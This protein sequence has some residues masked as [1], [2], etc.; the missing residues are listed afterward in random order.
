M[1]NALAKKVGKSKVNVTNVMSSTCRGFL[2]H[3]LINTAS[4]SI[5]M[6]I[7]IGHSLDS[8]ASEFCNI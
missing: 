7:K 8:F 1:E 3:S 6:V 5:L 2:E 4:H